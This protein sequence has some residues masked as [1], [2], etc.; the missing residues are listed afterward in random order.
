MA[1][2][3]PP[4]PSPLPDPL[5]PDPS[6]GLDLG[7]VLG[8]PPQMQMP[9]PVPLPQPSAQDPKQKILTL[10]ALGMMVGMGPR[11]GVGAAQGL[12]AA[13]QHLDTEKLRQF[14][15]QQQVQQQQVQQAQIEQRRQEAVFQQRQAALQRVLLDFNG[16]LKTVTTQDDYDRLITNYSAALQQGGYR[17]TPDWFRHEFKWTTPAAE[18]VL[19]KAIDKLTA[20]KPYATMTA[21]NPEAWRTMSVKIA[22]DP[23]HPEVKTPFTLPQAYAKLGI[24]FGGHDADGVP[25]FTALG[26]GTELQNHL[27]E[28]KGAFQAQFDRPPSTAADNTWLM[29]RIAKRNAD[30]AAQAADARRPPPDPVARELAQQ[31]VDEGRR[32]AK[33]LPVQTQ[34]RVDAQTRGFDA[35]GTVKRTQ[36]MADAV[37]F[38]T[39]LDPH[40]K[41][42][43]DDQALI[44]AFAKAMDPDSV[45]REGEYATVQ[46]YAQSWAESFGFNAQRMFKN[47]TF[48]TPAA[49]ANM[50][51]TIQ[52]KFG[53]GRAQYDNLRR[54]YTEKINKITGDTDGESYLTDYGGAFPEA[55]AADGTVKS[56]LSTDPNSGQPVRRP[57]GR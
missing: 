33:E 14:A 43:A 56:Y 1:S 4:D 46:K 10:A 31:R 53:A 50:K 7:A 13:Q 15:H 8:P 12:Q 25:Q 5:A 18:T 35:Q 19:Q 40:T 3:L 38:A 17:I 41:N 44:Y 26:K 54:S 55:P 52:S 36:L 21:D 34:R 51:A 20:S 49:R 47:T 32:K 42:P 29:D 57:G 48:L 6:L 37:G 27:I 23:Q 39:S 22:V 30:A 11:G 9:G 2:Q 28:A 24:E 16:Q 45:V